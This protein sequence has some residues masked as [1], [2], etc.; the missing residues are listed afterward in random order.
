MKKVKTHFAWPMLCQLSYGRSLNMCSARWD[1]N[2]QPSVSNCIVAVS[3]FQVERRA[4]PETAYPACGHWVKTWTWISSI[5]R[6]VLL[7]LLNGRLAFCLWINSARQDARFT[8]F[9]T[10]FNIEKRLSNSK[11]LNL[12]YG[13]SNRFIDSFWVNYVYLLFSIAVLR[14]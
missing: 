13:C 9:F 3:V 6:G 7:E 5:R 2:P 11:G 4:D 1:S 12:Q 8:L 14:L 10:V